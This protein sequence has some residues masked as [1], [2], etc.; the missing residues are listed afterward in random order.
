M[1]R[2][3]EEVLN[4]AFED[5]K[6]ELGLDWVRVTTNDPHAWHGSGKFTMEF[7]IVDRYGRGTFKTTWTDKNKE[8]I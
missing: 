7:G 5:I 8:V 6:P 3:E 4:Y 1:R 2:Y